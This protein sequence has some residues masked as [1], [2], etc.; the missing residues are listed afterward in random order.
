MVGSEYM[1]NK[2]Q[3]LSITPVLLNRGYVKNCWGIR[4]G[5]ALPNVFP[6]LSSRSVELGIFKIITLFK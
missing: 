3:A 5:E 2:E 1:G 6:R 4:W